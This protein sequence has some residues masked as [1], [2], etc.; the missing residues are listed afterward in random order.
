VGGHI[1]KKKCVGVPGNRSY[2]RRLV[3]LNGRTTDRASVLHKISNKTP[4]LKSWSGVGENFAKILWNFD[5]GGAQVLA[6]WRPPCPGRASIWL[7]PI[8]TPNKATLLS[9]FRKHSAVPSSKFHSARF[10]EHPVT[11]DTS[12]WLVSPR[13]HCPG[14]P[15]SRAA[16]QHRR[17]RYYCLYMLLHNDYFLIIW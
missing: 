3:G 15:L 1:T 7:N 8:F 12:R 4:K 13:F 2:T 11:F 5:A 17:L 6:C 10:I 16:I 9:S 14:C